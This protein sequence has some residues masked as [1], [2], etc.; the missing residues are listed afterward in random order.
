LKQKI[1][2]LLQVLEKKPQKDDISENFESKF[3]ITNGNYMNFKTN[4]E[5]IYKSSVETSGSSSQISSFYEIVNSKSSGSSLGSISLQEDDKLPFWIEK[6]DLVCNCPKMRLKR[7]YL[8]M[9]KS[10]NLL[11]YL[12]KEEPKS[13]E[14]EEITSEDNFSYEADDIDQE[15]ISTSASVISSSTTPTISSTSTEFSRLRRRSITETKL[16]LTNQR[17]AGL[18]VD[19]E[20]VIIEWRPEFQ[21][22]MRRFVKL[23]KNGRCS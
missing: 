20:T 15:D 19:R 16:E 8:V 9:V 5:T 11:K 17:L 12:P 14:D 4:V 21:R 22:R 13:D 18:L 7:K 23:F 6:K 1:V 2:M 3:Q 10:S